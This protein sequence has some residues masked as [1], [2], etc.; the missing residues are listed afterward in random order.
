MADHKVEQ[1]LDA[2]VPL[3]S[4][5]FTTGLNVKRGRVT[6]FKESTTA[7][8][9]IYQ[10][11]DNASEYN[12]PSVYSELTVF[13]DIHVKD[14]IEQVDQILNRSRMEINVAMMAINNL[15]LSFVVD[16]E[17]EGADEPEL[18]GE[19]HK[20]IATMRLRYKVKYNRNVNDPSL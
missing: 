1:I 2:V 16:I 7:A 18:S 4:G 11:S 19:S 20:P 10:G 3:V 6:P 13:I 9:S 12:W 14:S 8:L 17:E 5:L 15:G